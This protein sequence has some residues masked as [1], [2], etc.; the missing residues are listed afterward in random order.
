[1]DAPARPAPAILKAPARS[2]VFGS[3]V[4]THT[5]VVLC[6]HANVVCF[7]Y[8]C[9]F[10]LCQFMFELMYVGVCVCVG[11]ARGGD[12]TEMFVRKRMLRES[13][14]MIGNIRVL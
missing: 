7:M 4:S 13:L 8:V 1:M 6:R 2:Y 14:A 11:G 10:V 9:G 12:T 3:C 5:E